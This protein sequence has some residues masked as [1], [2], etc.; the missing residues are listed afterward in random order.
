MSN[1][2]AKL[3]SCI[4]YSSELGSVFKSVQWSD[5]YLEVISKQ[6]STDRSRTFRVST[7]LVSAMIQR[8]YFDLDKLWQELCNSVQFYSESILFSTQHIAFFPTVKDSKGRSAYKIYEITHRVDGEPEPWFVEFLTNEDYPFDL[9]IRVKMSM[10]WDRRHIYRVDATYLKIYFDKYCLDMYTKSKRSTTIDSVSETVLEAVALHPQD[11]DGYHEKQPNHMLNALLEEMIFDKEAD[12]LLVRSIDLMALQEYLEMSQKKFSSYRDAGKAIVE[13]SDSEEEVEEEPDNSVHITEA[14]L[15]H[16][17]LSHPHTV[18]TGLEHK[19]RHSPGLMEDDNHSVMTTDGGLLATHI[20]HHS[21]H[22]V[23][24]GQHHLPP[25]LDKYTHFTAHE[26]LSPTKSEVSIASGVSRQYNH[27]DH[28]NHDHDHNHLQSKPWHPQPSDVEFTD[29]SSTMSPYLSPRDMPTQLPLVSE[30]AD[31]DDHSSL[32]PTMSLQPPIPEG[33][34]RQTPTTFSSSPTTGEMQNTYNTSVTNTVSAAVTPVIMRKPRPTG[35]NPLIAK[36]ARDLH[37]HRMVREYIDVA[38]LIEARQLQQEQQECEEKDTASGMVVCEQAQDEDAGGKPTVTSAAIGDG[39]DPSS[40][41]QGDGQQTQ[42]ALEVEATIHLEEDSNK[43]DGRTIVQHAEDAATSTSSVAKVT[44]LQQLEHI[45]LHPVLPFDAKEAARTKNQHLA[46][47]LQSQQLTSSLNHNHDSDDG[48]EDQDEEEKLRSAFLKKDTLTRNAFVYEPQ[49]D[50]VHAQITEMID[51]NRAMIEKARHD[52]DLLLKNPLNQ[53]GNLATK[54]LILQGESTIGTALDVKLSLVREALSI[55]PDLRSAISTRTIIEFLQLHSPVLGAHTKLSSWDDLVTIAQ[56][57]TLVEMKALVMKEIAAREAKNL[58]PS[59]TDHNSGIAQSIT[60]KPGSSATL[61]KQKTAVI[62]GVDEEDVHNFL[63]VRRGQLI[64][65]LFVVLCGAITVSWEEEDTEAQV[66]ALFRRGPHH[67]DV[68]D[69]FDEE[70]EYEYDEEDDEGVD[71]DEIG[72]EMDDA[73]EGSQQ[74]Q[75]RKPAVRS[76]S[77]IPSSSPRKARTQRTRSKM[78]MKSLTTREDSQTR[79]ERLLRVVQQDEAAKKQARSHILNNKSRHITSTGSV[80]SAGSSALHSLHGSDPYGQHSQQKKMI[81]RHLVLTSGDVLGDSVFRG[82]YIHSV[83]IAGYAADTFVCQIPVGA[84]EHCVGRAGAMVEEY[85]VSFWKRL[86]LWGVIRGYNKALVQAGLYQLKVQQ[87]QL[88]LSNHNASDQNKKNSNNPNKDGING[89]NTVDNSNDPNHKVANTA[90]LHAQTMEVMNVIESARVRTYHAGEV[91]FQQDTP[92]HY[93]YIVRQGMAIYHR[94][95]NRL[96]QEQLQQRQQ[97]QRAEQNEPVQNTGIGLSGGLNGIS[98]GGFNANATLQSRMNKDTAFHIYRNDTVN[99]PVDH[100]GHNH[101]NRQPQLDEHANKLQDESGNDV[102]IPDRVETT[103]FYHALAPHLRNRSS[104][105]DP[106]HHT[107]HSNHSSS[108]NGSSDDRKAKVHAQTASA[109]A[110]N[111]T[112]TAASDAHTNTDNANVT[113][114]V[115]T[116]TTNATWAPPTHNPGLEVH[117]GGVLLSHDFSFLDSEDANRFL[118]RMKSLDAHFLGT[119]A[120][121][122]SSGQKEKGRRRRDPNRSG[123]DGHAKNRGENSGDSESDGESGTDNP[124]SHHAGTDTTTSA[125]SSPARGSATGGASCVQE[126]ARILAHRRAKYDRFGRHANTLIASTRCEVVVVQLTEIVKCWPLFHAL[127]QLAN[128]RYPGLQVSDRQVFV[129]YRLQQRWQE[130][131]PRVLRDIAQEEMTQML[132][133]ETYHSLSMYESDARYKARQPYLQTPANKPSYVHVNHRPTQSQSNQTTSEEQSDDNSRDNDHKMNHNKIKPDDGA[134]NPG[135]TTTTASAS[136]GSIKSGTKRKNKGNVSVNVN[137]SYPHPF[138]PRVQTK[139]LLVDEHEHTLQHLRAMQQ[140]QQQLQRDKM[141]HQQRLH[142]QFLD[143]TNHV[144]GHASNTLTLNTNANTNINTTNTGSNVAGTTPQGLL[145]PQPP[146]PRRQA[147]SK[148]LRSS[149][150]ASFDFRL[151]DPTKVASGERGRGTPTIEAALA[152]AIRAVEGDQMNNANDQVNNSNRSAHSRGGV[153]GSIRGSILGSIRGSV[154]EGEEGNGGVHEEMKYLS[155]ASFGYAN[156]LDA[157]LRNYQLDSTAPTPSSV[158]IVS[159]E[160]EGEKEEVG[161]GRGGGRGGGRRQSINSHA[162]NNSIANATVRSQSQNSST[163]ASIRSHATT[164]TSSTPQSPRHAR[165]KHRAKKALRIEVVERDGEDEEEEEEEVVLLQR[166]PRASPRPSTASTS[167]PR[168][169]SVAHVPLHGKHSPR[170]HHP[171]QG[172]S[173]ENHLDDYDYYHDAATPPFSTSSTAS[174]S[175]HSKSR[176]FSAP[177]T[178]S[179]AARARTMNHN[180]NHATE[181]QPNPWDSQHQHAL[182]PQRPSHPRPSSA[183]HSLGRGHSHHHSLDHR[184][185]HSSRN[186]LSQDPTRAETGTDVHNRGKRPLHYVT[187]L[188]DCDDHPAGAN[189]PDVSE[190]MNASVVDSQRSPS[191]SHGGSSGERYVPGGAS[192]LSALTMASSLGNSSHHHQMNSRTI[193][194]STYYVH[195]GS[196]LSGSGGVR[197]GHSA[198]ATR[199]DHTHHNEDDAAA[200]GGG[201]NED[202]KTNTHPHGNTNGS[203]ISH[204]P[205][206]RW[207]LETGAAVAVDPLSTPRSSIRGGGVVRPASAVSAS[208]ATLYS[209][210]SNGPTSVHTH[211]TSTARAAGTAA[212]TAAVRP[213]SAAAHTRSSKFS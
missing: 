88:N 32:Y 177:T 153:R 204:S 45:R 121:T 33:Y 62:E 195:V 3:Y 144:H 91:I 181:K 125:R 7:A 142:E 63:G 145:Q 17:P 5:D 20:L 171:H 178:Q 72:D 101:H 47:S 10:G 115:H 94:E 161:D 197:R 154:D 205:K 199:P 211:R 40:A 134:S 1:K 162:T 123:E 110:T 18:P 137:F 196:N 46:A 61:S 118:K 64:T 71:E 127:F 152:M 105:H 12:K 186:D 67:H 65:S 13:V 179:A 146:S 22:H 74:R 106:N 139:L 104:G 194:P 81:R 50:R 155:R 60:A 80:I 41:I 151:S 122:A 8:Y 14:D 93:L 39:H 200:I 212:A 187:R 11:E 156:V 147:P 87:L 76:S 92:R 69:D 52:A 55:R 38:D 112:N 82:D 131:Q 124:Q 84:I 182:Q 210:N 68:N 28:H 207:H 77:A 172:A 117:G 114:N 159:R 189:H 48:K 173:N 59:R 132:R 96:Q 25:P 157:A 44:V 206:I 4:D 126:S 143:Q 19:Y 176:P 150:R 175:A 111:T 188:E 193:D 29:D 42:Q 89:D 120:N 90:A 209:N 185:I 208:R 2:G 119:S 160:N 26:E 27:T 138:H 83:D 34:T 43:I 103:V 51:G 158:S 168:Q 141:L 86:R 79:F 213:R 58:P 149:L 192:V 49:L 75:T 85:M 136:T 36:I 183:L 202:A 109:Y 116:D 66:Q 21:S 6:P 95:L 73:L 191:S 170:S 164:T 166:S 24:A 37:P 133:E 78:P 102:Y 97:Q 169:G 100:P 108:T 113:T 54:R 180:D 31:A 107:N 128:V 130:A 35:I 135:P 30:S 129:H 140:Q 57:A 190:I 98:G 53:Q 9:E 148:A 174:G 15:T 56:S 70:D 16:S 184:A 198:P 203:S 165:S 23:P 167:S 201:D 163:G 99:T